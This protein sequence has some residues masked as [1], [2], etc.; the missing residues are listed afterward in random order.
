M[1]LQIERNW[2]REQLW[3]VAD[4]WL[5]NGMDPVNGGVYTCLDEN[6]QLYSTD[7]SVWMQGRCA[8]TFAQL[9]SQYGIRQEW[10]DASRSC[11]DFLEN[12]CINHEKGDRLYFTVTAEGK[13]LRQ[14]RYFASEAFYCM[15]NA[16]YYGVTGEKVYLERARWGYSRYWDLN[17]DLPDP[18]GMPPKVD[19]QT[20]A[21]KALGFPM[22]ML[23]VASIMRK[24]D[25]E[26]ADLYRAN[27]DQCV[28]Y[29]L[30][31]HVKPE[32]GAT[33][34]RVAPDGTPRLDIS[35]GRVVNP[36]HCIECSWFLM[37]RA[38]ITDDD[39]LKQQAIQIFDMAYE[40]GWDK[41]YGGLFYFIDCLGKP[42]EA[43]EHDMKLWWPHNEALIAS[44]M[45]YRETGDKKYR[46]IFLQILD[47]CKQ[48]FANAACGEWYGYL[49]RDGKPTMPAC[50][51]ST[52]KGPFHVPRCLMLVDQILGEMEKENG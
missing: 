16:A 5:K 43:Y 19:P 8:W 48:H 28:R 9:C 32:L 22:C 30:Q 47:Y 7:K 52:F 33:L 40:K 26:Q 45:I 27:S 15:G 14:R 49:R 3:E 38:R 18:V 42:P 25:P 2:F 1:R 35:D 51:G 37:E 13:P 50:I 20:R 41:E 29:I 17:H 44:L 36:G 12:H 34:E 31:R 10:L 6:G 24:V 11:L 46:E 23:N 39:A 21:A 4:F